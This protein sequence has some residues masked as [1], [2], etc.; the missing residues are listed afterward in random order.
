VNQTIAIGEM[1]VANVDRSKSRQWATIPLRWQYFEQKWLPEEWCSNN[2]T[3]SAVREASGW[4]GDLNGVLA[5]LQF[6]FSKVL[7]DGR[8]NTTYQGSLSPSLLTLH[9]SQLIIP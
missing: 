6:T 1:S 3:E 2:I 8:V 9:H 5:T 7:T 4:I